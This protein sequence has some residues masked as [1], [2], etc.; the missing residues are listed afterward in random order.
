MPGRAFFLYIVCCVLWGSTWL[1]IKIGL[2]DLP[3][4]LFAGVRMT[5]ASLILAPVALR[6]GWPRLSRPE[7]LW[8][9]VVGLLQ[10]GLSYAGIFAAERFIDSGLTALLFCSFP[11]WAIAFAHLLIPSERATPLH[12]ASAALGVLGVG[13]LEAPLIRPL[14]MTPELAVALLL[15]LGSAACSA[16]GNVLQK[17]HLRAVPLAA[18]LWVQA[19][20]GGGLLLTMHFVLEQ[21]SPA[22]WT[23]RALGALLY[24][25]IPGT[26]VTF[27]ALFWLIPRLP[28]ALIGAIP[29]ID[30]VIALVLGAVVLNEP[31]GWRL[32]AGAILVLAGAALAS[33]IRSVPEGIP[34]IGEP[35]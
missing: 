35:P 12:L 20:I 18:N 16:L 19:M 4:F 1:V 10:L 14:E 24:L 34:L 27:L 6:S 13:I 7:W 9:A 30:T 32:V 26:V 5:V 8:L 33:Q 31:F 23:P 29:L 28:I 17:R 22:H 15:P 3:S 25:A 11:I 2:A 21:R